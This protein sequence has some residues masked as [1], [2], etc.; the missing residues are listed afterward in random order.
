MKFDQQQPK[1]N[2]TR[3]LLL[4]LWCFN[5]CDRQ[6][7]SLHWDFLHDLQ[8]WSENLHI[9]SD[10]SPPSSISADR[11]NLWRISDP[12]VQVSYSLR[13][14]ITLFMENAY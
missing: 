14:A 11:V 7:L 12:E 4:C 10:R 1:A 8:S 3:G 9:H 5:F 2:L 6:R 13:L